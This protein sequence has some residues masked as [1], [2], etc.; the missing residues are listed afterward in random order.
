MLQRL[1]LIGF[2]SFAEKTVFD[3]SP[4]ITAI[5]GPNGSGKSNV[6]DAIRWVLGEQSIK[7]L[8]GQEMADVIFNGS[9]T[10]R[11]LGIAEVTMTFDNTSG[12]LTTEA[13]EV[14]ISRRIYRDGQSEYLING[15][16]RRLKDIRDLFLGSGAGA[17]AYCIIEQGRVEVL[18][19]A[20]TKDRR[21]IFEEAAGIS[22]FKAK[23]T[24]SL[25][26]LER[27]SLNLERLRDILDELDKQLRSVQLQAAKAERYQEYQARLKQLRVGLGLQEYHQIDQKLGGESA[28]LGA[29]REQLHRQASI[30][31]AQEAELR[32]V[33]D[34][35]SSLDETL[36]AQE[37][38]L[39]Q[40]RQRIA[41]EQTTLEHERESSVELEADL[42]E[43]RIRH[44]ELSRRVQTL[45][46]AVEEAA[47]E[48][49]SAEAHCQSQADEVQRH[50]LDLN[51]FT[52]EVKQLQDQI[53][54]DK[55]GH[56]E[57]LRQA[58]YWHNDAI[59][60]KA[61]HDTLCRER[62][63]LRQRTEQVVGHLASLDLELRDLTTAEEVVQNRLGQARQTLAHN[64]AQSGRL[65]KTLQEDSNLLADQRAR[66]SGLASRIEVL[67]GLENSQEGLGA[68]AREM[69]DW[70]N[71]EPEMRALVPG[72]VVDLLTV[73]REDAA[74]IDLAL[75]QTAQCFVVRDM[76]ALDRLVG[77]RPQAFSGRVSFIRLQGPVNPA[78]PA[79]SEGL[80]APEIV[81]RASQF[82]RC[83][84]HEFA[85]LP[86]QLL[87][88]TLLVKD[89]ATAR[90]LST[91]RP[92]CR[93]LTAQNELL[94][95]DGTLTVGAHHADASILSRKAELRDLREQVTAFDGRIADVEH[96]IAAT[97]EQIS[98]LKS[99]AE[100]QQRE[101]EVLAEQANDL[102]MRIGQH[103]QQ[104]AGLH[105]EVNVGRSELEGLDAEILT[106]E[107]T[108]KQA[109][110]K[111]EAA[112]GI[113]AA[114]ESRLS[115]SE[116]AIR[117]KE[118]ARQ[119]VQRQLT[120]AKVS[121]AQTEERRNSLSNR[122]QQ[123][124]GDLEER[125]EEWKK[126]EDHRQTT[127]ARLQ[128]SQM[129]MLEAESNLVVSYGEKEAAERESGRLQQQREELRNARQSLLQSTQDSRQAWEAKREEVH[130][131]ELQ[132]NDLKHQCE[133]LVGRLREEYQIEMSELYRQA[134][135]AG[136]W[137]TANPAPGNSSEDTKPAA[138]VLWLPASDAETQ[139][140]QKEIEELRRK[141]TRLGNVNLEALQ[142][143]NELEKRAASLRGQADDLTSAKRSLEDI[144][145]KINEDSRKLFTDAFE[146][147]RTHFQELFRKL[148]GGG[149]ADIELEEPDDVL[150]SG[151]EIVARP[152]GKEMRNL[153]LMSGGEKTLTAVALLLAI[154][155]SK[156]SPFCI[157]DE[158]DAPL[159]EA[160]IGRFT[161]VLREF[162]DRSQFILITHSKRTMASA[163]V[164][165]GVTMQESGVSKR[166]AVR[167]EDWP[168][169][170]NVAEEQRASA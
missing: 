71:A 148:F 7:S 4:G 29:L 90:L 121:F 14:Q 129:A 92:D 133:T 126:G 41:T 73:G 151:I 100:R 147:I 53:Q 150:E 28:T 85:G 34:R 25:R 142:E 40:A 86:E 99:I 160:N 45:A 55:A 69:A 115:G 123:A 132:V 31:Q 70:L 101:V 131:L 95:S 107:Q 56:F 76:E 81:A 36:R 98:D 1:D 125:R 161:S 135:D 139:E 88:T 109:Q 68:G 48:L 106:Q 143:L 134:R 79:S 144:I 5:V 64:Q 75:G 159:D 164:L 63:R 3:F 9:A 58:A 47:A 166:V 27:V 169:D 93:F 50:E 13:N 8:R 163:D 72:M 66:R 33:E 128:A 77:S 10:R 35:L 113:V 103:R 118:S 32:Q 39:T 102:R 11:S 23:K 46:Q 91:Q 57:Q 2:K 157:L 140:A 145:G 74:R 165:Y 80:N 44:S 15:A 137:S 82:V 170:G 26:K 153:S 105:E 24:E 114:L 162:L 149:M 65:D 155:R 22:R 17:D 112:E 62:D 37:S 59:S 136:R 156:P 119:L 152:P 52:R 12:T 108:W 61:H 104:R 130:H 30:S 6:V 42:A 154:F 89:L 84:D 124:S 97:R 127:A 20:S 78:T 18:L 21:A 43:T 87:G 138:A 94:D 38:L 111:A 110:A 146:A 60:A 168:D 67:Q 16:I 19:Q 167:F 158:V 116:I 117:E 51:N 83:E 120:A 54:E 141:L 96:G 122:H 49:K